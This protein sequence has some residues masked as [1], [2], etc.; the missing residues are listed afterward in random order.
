MQELEGEA[1]GLRRGLPGQ[2]GVHLW[3]RPAPPRLKLKSFVGRVTETSQKKPT[4]PCCGGFRR[5]QP[6]KNLGKIQGGQIQACPTWAG[7]TREGDS[8]V[9]GEQTGCGLVS[10][11]PP[12]QTVILPALEAEGR[13][14]VRAGLLS[15]EA[16]PPGLKV[17][18]FF[19]CPRVAFSCTCLCLLF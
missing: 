11:G 5:E 4:P 9:L 19:P 12:T 8:G 14:Q 6:G 2:E 17:A 10:E 18:V 1:P 16:S 3:G 7:A 13:P 15:P